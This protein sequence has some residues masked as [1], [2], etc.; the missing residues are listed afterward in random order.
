MDAFS[1]EIYARVS[2]ISLEPILKIPEMLKT[3]DL[4][5]YFAILHPSNQISK[6]EYEKYFRSLNMKFE[7]MEIG[8]SYNS[9][10]NKN[11]LNIEQI[12]EL[13]TKNF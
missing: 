1:R 6:N 8:S 5:K 7:Q 9:K 2:S 3:F 11:F 10:D 12:R 13:I 4:G